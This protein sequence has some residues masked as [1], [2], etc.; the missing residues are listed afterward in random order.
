MSHQTRCGAATFGRRAVL[1]HEL[2]G[3]GTEGAPSAAHSC[4]SWTSPRRKL[5][6]LYAPIGR[7]S[8]APEILLRTL[9]LQAFYSV[10]SERQL[11]EQRNHVR[12]PR[13][14]RLG[15]GCDGVHQEQ[16]LGRRAARRPRSAGAAY[17]IDVYRLG[18]GAPL[19]RNPR[20]GYCSELTPEDRFPGWTRPNR[21]PPARGFRP[22]RR[23]FRMSGEG[24]ALP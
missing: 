9:L 24:A 22:A 19:I 8:M 13:H 1:R 15:V 20:R 12:G 7:P 23:G 6:R 3:A 17:A 16:F 2:R 4:R 5:Q 21:L 18:T 11:M 10:R 14:R